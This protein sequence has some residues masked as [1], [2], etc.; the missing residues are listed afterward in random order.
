MN[1]FEL[2]EMLEKKR[3][4]VKSFD[5]LVDFLKYV[6]DNCNTGYGEAPRA[7]AQACLAVGYYFAES[8]GITGFQAGCVMWD[9]I[10]GWMYPHNKCGLKLVNYDGM[11]FPQYRHKY[12]K[13]ITR[14][15]WEALQK[16][17]K[18]NLEEKNVE[19]V[20]PDVLAH[21]DSI[22]KGYV[23]FGYTVTKD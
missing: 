2:R 16:R 10:Y 23:P 15:V 17:A 22:A 12:E 4:E 20:H 19:F 6:E 9:F 18:E 3:K 11:L 5:E 21:W 13:T 1:E 7:M 14:S 8:F